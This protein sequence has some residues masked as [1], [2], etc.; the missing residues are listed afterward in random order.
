MLL[1]INN[2]II[3]QYGITRANLANNASATIFPISFTTYARIMVSICNFLGE[4]YV[5]SFTPQYSINGFYAITNANSYR[6]AH[7][8]A[9]G[10]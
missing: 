2:K 5:V 4:Y 3:L 10:F 6:T 7:W 9:I 1:L 8:L